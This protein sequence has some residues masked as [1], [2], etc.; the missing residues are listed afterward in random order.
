MRSKTILLMEAHEDSRNIC[1][2]VL[3]H[4]GYTVVEAVDGD[5]GVRLARSHAPDLIVM[6]IVLPVVDGWTAAERLRENAATA[7]IPIIAV[8]TRTAREDRQRGEQFG[9]AAYLVKP[10]SPRDVLGEVRRVIG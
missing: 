6:D 8:T 4:F 2:M 10:C 3:R 1:S 5:A 9:F 7:L